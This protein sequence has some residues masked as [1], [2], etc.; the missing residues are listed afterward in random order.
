MK[1]RTE[2]T[3]R[4]QDERALDEIQSI[5]DAVE[6]ARAAQTKFE[7]IAKAQDIPLR[8]CPCRQRRGPRPR[9]QRGGLCPAS[10]KF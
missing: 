2:L 9:W 3:K 1:S 6:D 5:Y 8:R 4:L 7:D 10:R